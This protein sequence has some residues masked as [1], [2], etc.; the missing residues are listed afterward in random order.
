VLDVCPPAPGQVVAG[1]WPIGGE[2]DI[3]PLLL[4][5]AGRGHVIA[6]PD[7]PRRGER[8][9]FHRWRQG[10]RLIPERFGTFRP[11]DDPVVPD[12]LLVPLLG[13]DR[14]GWRIGYGGGFYDRTLEALPG[15]RTVGC[16]FAAQEVA[17]VPVEAH[18]RRLD[19]IATEQEVILIR[20]G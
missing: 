2:I 20:P 7:M 14:A 19:A 12:Y 1:F 4:G 9:T 18:D 10:D 3:R 15:R 16:A 6:L 5:L 8:L 11:Q 17:E 13:F